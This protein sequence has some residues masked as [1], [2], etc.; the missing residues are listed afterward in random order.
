VLAIAVPFRL[1]AG[2]SY[3]ICD[4]GQELAAAQPRRHSTAA[5]F[6][7]EHLRD[8]IL[9]GHLPAGAPLLLE[10]LAQRFGT[11]VIP[12]RE[13]LQALGAE[14]LVVL[15]PHRTASVAELDL[16]SLDQLYP[17]GCTLSALAIG[18]AHGKLSQRD[19]A[20][21]RELTDALERAAL[22]GDHVTPYA[23]H[24][25]IHF[26]FY[27]ATGSRVLLR[28]LEI[29]WDEIGRYHH[30]L[31]PFTRT[32]EDIQ[33]WVADHRRLIDLLEHGTA[34]EAVEEMKAII[35]RWSEPLLEAR[36]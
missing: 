20:D 8:D 9:L 26:R 32:R 33:A 19:F 15:R 35:T 27:E 25:K 34:D 23:L 10:E 16:A 7:A 4:M 11:S 5:E 18:A 31:T 14:H 30:L 3:K 17:L 24:R 2:R 13:A 28:M 36:A 29:L 21:V 22:A 6:V 12:V 1:L